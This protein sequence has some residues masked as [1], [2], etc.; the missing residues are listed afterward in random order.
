MKVQQLYIFVEDKG[1]NDYH[2]IMAGDETT[3]RLILRE[4]VGDIAKTL[5]LY[6]VYTLEPDWYICSIEY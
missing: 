1:E 6:G 5:P 3:A 2:L 4:L